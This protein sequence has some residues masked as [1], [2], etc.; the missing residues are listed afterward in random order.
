MKA[1]RT[2]KLNQAKEGRIIDDRV[3]S[4][5]MGSLARRTTALEPASHLVRRARSRS[6]QTEGGVVSAQPMLSG[7]T[8]HETNED[9][10]PAVD[11]GV[12]KGKLLLRHL[13]AKYREKY[14]DEPCPPS[15]PRVFR[16][17]LFNL[18]APKHEFQQIKNLQDFAD[19]MLASLKK[20]LDDDFEVLFLTSN[21]E[22]QSLSLLSHQQHTSA[23]TMDLE[24]KQLLVFL[25]QPPEQTSRSIESETKTLRPFQYI[26]NPSKPRSIRTPAASETTCTLCGKSVKVTDEFIR[27]LDCNHVYH[28]ICLIQAVAQLTNK[29]FFLTKQERKEHPGISLCPNCKDAGFIQRGLVRGYRKHIIWD[30]LKDKADVFYQR[31]QE[32]RVLEGG[33]TGLDSRQ[34]HED[35]EDVAEE[36]ALE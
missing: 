29:R 19:L 11:I 18:I 30:L 1:V 4:R 15:N 20:F 35:S 33:S 31:M 7:T 28:R 26:F 10:D 22:D 3:D 14:H 2:A 9:E 13:V 27:L 12:Q 24:S 8:E 34:T 32:R 5:V 25:V 36:N 6:R 16:E 23:N 17:M 21:A